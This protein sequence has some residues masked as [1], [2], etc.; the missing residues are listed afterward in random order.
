MF[1]KVEL[2]PTGIS[3]LFFDLNF[4]LVGGRESSIN[5][6]RGKIGKGKP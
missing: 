5:L 3:F 4:D 1:I 6:T 2:R